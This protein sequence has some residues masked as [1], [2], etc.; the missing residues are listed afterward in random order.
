MLKRLVVQIVA[1]IAQVSKLGSHDWHRVFHIPLMWKDSSTSTVRPP[2]SHCHN[3]GSTW[4]LR[5]VISWRYNFPSDTPGAAKITSQ[6]CEI[7]TPGTFGNIYHFCITLSWDPSFPHNFPY[8]LD[9]LYCT[10]SCQKA[11]NK[12]ALLVPSFKIINSN[13]QRTSNTCTFL[14]DN[15][16]QPNDDGKG[17]ISR[18]ASLIYDTSRILT[19]SGLPYLINHFKEFGKSP[20]ISLKIHRSN[21]FT[22]TIGQSPLHSIALNESPIPYY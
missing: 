16:Q 22:S 2:T 12:Y 8:V 18:T 11:S 3:F 7:T 4:L 17:P 14:L 6:Y 19:Y 10:S 13:Q 15:H 20:G 1:V 5:K 21:T 9:V